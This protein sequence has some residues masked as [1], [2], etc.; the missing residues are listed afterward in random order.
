MRKKEQ[1]FC[2][3][4]LPVLIS[5]IKI[6]QAVQGNKSP[7]IFRDNMILLSI[8]IKNLQTINLELFI[9]EFTFKVVTNFIYLKGYPLKL[10]ILGRLHLNV[11]ELQV[12]ILVLFVVF[13]LSQNSFASLLFLI[14]K[15]AYSKKRIQNV[16]L[17]Y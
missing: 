12:I 8:C 3:Q 5:I 13:Y 2:S 14:V 16:L 10:F 4:L 1:M 6:F 11:S 9:L 7:I 17:V 15:L